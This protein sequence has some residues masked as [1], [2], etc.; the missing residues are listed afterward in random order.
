MK[1]VVGSILRRSV[2]PPEGIVGGRVPQPQQF[3][4]EGIFQ[5]GR[6]PLYFKG[7]ILNNDGLL[8]S[9][10]STFQELDDPRVFHQSIISDYV[11]ITQV[12]GTLGEFFQSIPHQL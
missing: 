7:Y 9:V 8:N 1:R 11:N 5:H 2:Q 3:H 10:Q 4:P 12:A 6:G